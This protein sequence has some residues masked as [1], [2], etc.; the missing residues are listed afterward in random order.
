MYFKFIEMWAT[1]NQACTIYYQLGKDVITL[2]VALFFGFQTLH[3]LLFH[4]TNMLYTL[5]IL[6]V[7]NI[8]TL[9]SYFFA[10]KRLGHCHYKIT[11]H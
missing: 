10:S 4:A 7:Q 2:C 5:Y 9:L 3:N 6:Y 8:N 1:H 11:I